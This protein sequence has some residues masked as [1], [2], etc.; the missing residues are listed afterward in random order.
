M[1]EQKNMYG[2]IIEALKLKF[3]KKDL[4]KAANRQKD[5]LKL[6]MRTWIP[7][8]NA[9]LDMIA[10]RLPSPAT[11]QAYR[12]DNLYSG[13]LDSEEAES[14]RKCDSSGAMSMYISKMV[15][16]AEKGRFI[17]FGRVFSGTIKTGQEIRI[18]GPDFVQG[19]KKR[20]IY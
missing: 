5:Y 19:K 11:A 8:G 20:F 4:D 13:P 1:S 18:L 6:V 17:A 10:E 16:T 12:V 2:P 15:P 3:T 7:A 14:I 9:L